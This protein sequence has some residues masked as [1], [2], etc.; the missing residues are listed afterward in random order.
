VNNNEVLTIA[1]AISTSTL[2]SGGG[3]LGPEDAVAFITSLVDQS[4]ILTMVQSQKVVKS[5]KN[6]DILHT[7]SRQLRKHQEGIDPGFRAKIQTG[8]NQISTVKCMLPVEIT[9]DTFEEN[10]EKD[11]FETTVM[12]LFTLLYGN[13]LADLAINGDANSADA[14]LSINDGWIALA[15]SRCNNVDNDSSVDY[16][17]NFTAMIKDMPNR[18]KADKTKLFFLVSSNDEIGYRAQIAAR[19]TSMGDAYLDR[20]M[21]ARF[22]G[23]LVEPIEYLDDG[24]HLLTNPK[25]LVFGIEYG[26]K[27]ARDTDIFADTRQFAI[28]TKNDFE[29]ELD[30]AVV[31]SWDMP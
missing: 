30:D 9:E 22:Q 19:Q 26:I 29:M 23:I 28:T 21:R 25:N 27:V 18:F 11:G 2:A 24:I 10:I 1:K 4:K 14:F 16:I 12:N 5:P 8:R 6:I 7:A 31:I 15:K 20:D 13:D 17:D 3:L